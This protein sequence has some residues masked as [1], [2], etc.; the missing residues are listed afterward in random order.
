MKKLKGSLR[1]SLLRKSF[2]LPVCRGD[3]VSPRFLQTQVCELESE[4][5]EL[6]EELAC[7]MEELALTQDAVTHATE[8]LQ[9]L[10]VERD[11]M[12]HC[13]KKVEEMSKR[14][15]RRKLSEFGS[16]AE[17]ALWFAESFGLIPASVNVRTSEVISVPLSDSEQPSTTP[18]CREV[19][20]YVALQTLYILDRFGV[21]DE[22][23]HELTQVIVFIVIMH[24]YMSLPLLVYY[25]QNMFL[26]N[27]D[28]S[29]S[30]EESYYSEVASHQA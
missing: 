5:C 7:A 2:L 3:T 16:A 8:Q 4:V 24:V 29:E 11:E 6:E 30:P 9:K 15:R 18:E 25:V 28:V 27:V 21:S 13:G 23:Y 22:F 12:V 10:V 1:Q 19:D 20:E 14:H 17:S 26:T